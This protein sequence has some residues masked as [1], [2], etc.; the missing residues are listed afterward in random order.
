ME[1]FGWLIWGLACFLSLWGLFAFFREIFRP[2][3]FPKGHKACYPLDLRRLISGLYALGMTA[4]AVATAVLYISKLHLLWFVPL[5]H[6]FGVRWIGWIYLRY[7]YNAYYKI[8]ACL[9]EAYALL[10]DVYEC[11]VHL[12]KP[13]TIGELLSDVCRMYKNNKALISTETGEL[14][15]HACGALQKANRLYEENTRET[16][17]QAEIDESVYAGKDLPLETCE[18][19]LPYL[20]EAGDCFNSVDILLGVQRAHLPD[21]RLLKHLFS[22]Y[23][24]ASH[25]TNM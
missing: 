13:P 5:Y 3:P 8:I 22:F 15:W 23:N 21:F 10:W 20:N 16:S 25:R 18:K 6:F 24:K 9:K 19:M 11:N 12:K 1:I 2:A 4:A 7:W 14:L 17:C